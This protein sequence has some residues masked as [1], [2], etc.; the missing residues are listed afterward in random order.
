MHLLSRLYFFSINGHGGGQEETRV[1][2][3]WAVPGP[4]VV[5]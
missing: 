3:P 2:I 5:V 1:L 4:Q